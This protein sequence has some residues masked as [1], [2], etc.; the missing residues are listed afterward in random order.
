METRR[1]SI[2]SIQEGDSSDDDESHAQNYSLF[3]VSALA[4]GQPEPAAAASS[5][6]RGGKSK[7]GAGKQRL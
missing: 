3:V 2:S 5:S 4:S 7:N 6:G 1:A